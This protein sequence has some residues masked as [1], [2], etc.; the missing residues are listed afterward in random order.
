[1]VSLARQVLGGQ[2]GH[3]D[4]RPLCIKGD[5]KNIKEYW[6][7]FHDQL[8]WERGPEGTRPLH[9]AARHGHVEVVSFLLSKGAKINSAASFNEATP[10]YMASEARQKECQ[11]LLLHHQA[12]VEGVYETRDGA[13]LRV[14]TGADGKNSLHKRLLV[15]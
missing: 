3:F 9:E 2:A 15:V 12:S 4:L 6:N 7:R 10:L 1:M 8:E 14:M 13:F 5:L 11:V